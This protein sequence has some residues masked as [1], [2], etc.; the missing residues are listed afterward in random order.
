[1]SVSLA[2][3][4]VAANVGGALDGA[5]CEA[6]EASAKEKAPPERGDSAQL[7]RE[8]MEMSTA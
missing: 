4:K 3:G 1:L 2:G 6:G 5:R 8:I 7:N